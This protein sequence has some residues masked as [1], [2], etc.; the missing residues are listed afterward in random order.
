K[1]YLDLIGELA[2][3]L[4]DSPAFA[5]IS[6][7]LML[8]WQWAGYNALPGLKFGYE[9]WTISQFQKETGIAVPG[10][11]DDPKRF[12]Q[13]FDFLTG[14]KREE[15][16]DWRCK[17]IFAFHQ[18]LRD[19]IRQAKPDARLF[20]N[21]FGPGERESIAKDMFG[22]MR[23]IGMDPKLYDKEPGFVV[24]QGG[25]YGRR[26]S[27]PLMDAGVIEPSLYSPQAK[28]V[29][30]W[31]DRGYSLYTSYFEYGH[32]A[33]FDRLGG[34]DVFINECCVPSG[35]N[36]R[37]LY[38]IALADCDTSFL[39]NGG[40]GWMFGTPSVMQPFL[41]EYRALPAIPFTPWEKARDPVAVWS[42]KDHGS[43]FFY[44]VNRLP[45]K[46]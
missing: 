30:R 42:A 8:S 11:A 18:R 45:V 27:S 1:K 17:K 2:D 44:A 21:Y 35:F 46:V 19:R 34:K 14:V 33:E 9:D 22:Q 23:E 39:I 15:W 13:R 10:N 41:R 38:A 26:Y 28:Q 36:E 6:C 29:R 31:G 7:R 24:I 3:N 12:R 4:K 43:L 25:M 40:A 32:A 37:E 16:L 5:G 20:L